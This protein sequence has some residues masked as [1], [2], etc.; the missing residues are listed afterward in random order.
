[1]KNYQKLTVFTAAAA[2]LITGCSKEEKL[3][4]KRETLF[5]DSVDEKITA[6]KDFSPIVIEQAKNYSE[7]PQPFLNESHSYAPHNFSLNPQQ[8]WS[9]SLDFEANKVLQN[10]AS[11]VVAEGKVFAADAAGIIYAIDKKTGKQLWRVSTNLIEKDGQI[12]CAM[13]YAN[14]ALIV[15]DSFSINAKTGKIL[16][17]IKLP[18]VC[19]GDGITIANGKAF[20]LCSNSSINAIDL[21]NGK[22][23]WTH[24][25]MVSD[26]VFLGSSGACFSNGILY[27]TYPSG[28]IF[29]LHAENGSEIWDNAV[30]KFSLMKAA[31]ARTHIRACP[32]VKDGKLYIVS[33]SG[34]ISAFDAGTGAEIWSRNFGGLQTPI[35]S[36]N[37]VFLHSTNSELVC[38]NKDTG[39][40][41]WKTVLAKNSEDEND[42]YAQLLIKDHILSISPDGKAFFISVHNGKIKKVMNIGVKITVNP[43]ISDKTMY[44]LTTDSNISAYR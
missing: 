19:K 1:M 17:R 12:G 9:A 6:Q 43:V 31:H 36:G 4:G 44:I 38:L 25:G 23:L 24:S 22:T 28:E 10:T 2:L 11:P 18:S 8:I 15:S 34:Q 37:S 21:S 35:I 27:V 5:Y 3:R 42:W 29:A 7:F 32:V 26:S 14:G 33:P 20:L 39:T 16:W 13:A 41:K 40:L 30:S